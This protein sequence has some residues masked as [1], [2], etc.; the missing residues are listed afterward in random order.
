MIAEANRLKVKS[1]E[2]NKQRIVVFNTRSKGKDGNSSL[3]EVLHD[4]TVMNLVRDTKAVMEI[5]AFKEFSDLP[6][7]D[8]DRVCYDT[9]NVEM[10]HEL[11]AIETLL[12]TDDLYES[13]EIETR[14]KY[15][16]F[17]ESEKKTGGK[18]FEF[19]SEH[20]SS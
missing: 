2:N 13:V 20:V 19:S 17:V 12:I 11:K 7:T 4:S 8:L 9:K 14:Y 10:A 5:K 6:T 18:A 1:V 16:G 15:R 3:L